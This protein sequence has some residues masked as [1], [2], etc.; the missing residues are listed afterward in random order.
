[1]KWL[2]KGTV[3]Y[4]DKIERVAFQAISQRVSLHKWDC[5]TSAAFVK[6]SNKADQP[7]EAAYVV[8]CPAYVAS[9][10]NE[11]STRKNSEFMLLGLR[12]VELGTWP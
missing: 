7:L 12:E 5:N 9:V 1:M 6:C 3:P 4:T 2:Q 8:L 11:R 10:L